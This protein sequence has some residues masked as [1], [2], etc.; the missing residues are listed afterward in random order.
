MSTVAATR[1]GRPADPQFEERVF[2]AA[3][4]VYG[5]LGW[6]G[7]TFTA[8]CRRARVGKSA[9]YRRWSQPTDLLMAAVDSVLSIEDPDTGHLRADLIS[10]ARQVFEAYLSPHG[11]AAFRL[12]VDQF[13]YPELAANSGRFF[14][15]QRGVAFQAVQRGRARGEIRPGAEPS[16]ILDLVFGAVINH[17]LAYPAGRRRELLS[18]VPGWCEHLVDVVLGSVS[19]AGAWSRR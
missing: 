2:E 15:R 11:L 9:M 5:E 17:L 14:E 4:D 10:L 19:Q 13:L 3:L 8:I 6:P 16:L 1:R 7:F 18:S 12:N